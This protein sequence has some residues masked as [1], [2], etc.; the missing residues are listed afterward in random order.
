MEVLHS[1]EWGD[2]KI[3]KISNIKN[4]LTTLWICVGLLMRLSGF[5]MVTN[6]LYLLFG[7]SNDIGSKH[8]AFSDFR[9]IERGMA[10]ASVESFKRGHL[11]A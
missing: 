4:Q 8:L 2:T 3:G 10:L 5:Q 1:L 7:F 6:K 11:Q 9:P